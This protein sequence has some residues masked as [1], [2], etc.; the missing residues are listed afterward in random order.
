MGIKDEA[1]I[2]PTQ[3]TDFFLA[4]EKIDPEFAIYNGDDVMLLPTI[5]Q[6]AMGLVSGGAH[7]FG[8]EIRKIF[9]CFAEGKNEEAK[10]LFIPFLQNNRTERKNSSKLYYAS[11]CRVSNRH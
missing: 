7:I 6:G 8:H 5:V 10:E 9:E 4:T 2:N 11:C 1:G 3:V